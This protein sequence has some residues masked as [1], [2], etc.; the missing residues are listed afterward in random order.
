M[1]LSRDRAGFPARPLARRGLR[2]IDPD[3]YLCEVADELADDVDATVIRL[4]GEKRRP[5]KTPDD[6]LDDLAHAGVPRF[7]AKLRARLDR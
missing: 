1:L 2:V 5:P 6:L 4:S 3:T 7:A